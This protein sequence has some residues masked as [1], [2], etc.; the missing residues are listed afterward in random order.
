MIDKCNVDTQAGATSVYRAIARAVCKMIEAQV[1][2]A[3]EFDSIPH[4]AAVNS[5][6]YAAVMR[7]IDMEGEW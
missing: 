5:A 3:T 4:V 7:S 6:L 2:R 1:R